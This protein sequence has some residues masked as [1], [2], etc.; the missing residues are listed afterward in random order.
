MGCLVDLR[1]RGG[2]CRSAPQRRANNNTNSQFFFNKAEEING[3][4]E[5]NNERMELICGA[6]TPSPNE[7]KNNFPFL[8]GFAKRK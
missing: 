7:K 5:L 4:L 8:F 1:V 2:S 3:I 6:A